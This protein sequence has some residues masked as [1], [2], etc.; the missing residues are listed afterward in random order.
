[1]TGAPAVAAITA[2][3]TFGSSGGAGGSSAAA[4][5]SFVSRNKRHTTR[6]ISAMRHSWW[7]SL[8]GRWPRVSKLELRADWLSI[9]QIPAGLYGSESAGRDIFPG[10]PDQE[11]RSRSPLEIHYIWECARHP[12]KV[13]NHFPLPEEASLDRP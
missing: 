5:G 8:L 11:R 3:S 13:R 12:D 7:A 6:F 4:T 9:R 10:Q 1:M 2:T